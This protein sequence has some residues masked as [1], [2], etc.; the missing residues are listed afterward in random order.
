MFAIIDVETTGGAVNSSRIIE[1]G[2]AISDGK[3]IVDRY[4]SLVN[5]QMPIPPFIT[6]LTG[7]TNE[8]VLHAP[9]FEE[10]AGVV[11]EKIQG[12]IFVAHNV[13]FDYPIVS[14]ELEQCGYTLGK[15]K[16][17]TVRY[18][19]AVQP[20]LSSYSLKNLAKHFD[21]VNERHHRALEDAETAA[22]I[23]HE[24]LMLDAENT[25][26]NKQ[27]KGRAGLIRLPLNLPQSDFESLPNTPGVYYMKGSEQNPI[28][29][30]KAIH[31]KQRVI[32]HF[33]TE[34]ESSKKVQWFHEISGLR[35]EETGSEALAFLLEDFEIR[36]YWPKYNKAQKSNTPAFGV[37][38]YQDGYGARRLAI[39]RQKQLSAALERFFSFNAAQEWLI[40]VVMRYK[41]QPEK[42]GLPGHLVQSDEALHDQG[43]SRL[44]QDLA[45]IRA[46][47]EAFFFDGRTEHEMGYVLVEGGRYRG[48]GFTSNADSSEFEELLAGL[49]C[50]HESPTTHQI[51]NWIRSSMSFK[52]HVVFD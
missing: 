16:L 22:R 6:Q 36:K 27:V 12:Q 24:L 47:R 3:S 5:P 44:K 1:I 19:R 14:R 51:I 13:G 25:F 8:D 35:Y 32:Q 30:G 31:L 15:D 50:F 49:R 11:F 46:R 18:G 45:G 26:F 20:G 9:S 39:N 43:L 37:F 34:L 40:D 21:I 41:L 48:I 42:C 4:S 38:E 29:I 23:L 28:Y 2:I 10:I 7:I 52:N 17:C 33:T